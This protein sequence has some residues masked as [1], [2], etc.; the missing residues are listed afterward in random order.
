MVKSLDEMVSKAVSGTPAVLT[1]WEEEIGNVATW[2]AICRKGGV[3]QSTKKI[4]YNLNLDLGENIL[5][6]LEIKLALFLRR[7]VPR[8]QKW[9]SQQIEEAV[10]AFEST[11]RPS[12][13][14]VSSHIA[15]SL[16]NFFQNLQSRLITYNVNTNECFGYAIKATQRATDKATKRI[17]TTMAPGYATAATIRGIQPIFVVFNKILTSAIRQ[18]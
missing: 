5:H 9:L 6:G 1:K 17:K 10:T 18:T 16:E 15:N 2:R 4:A 8:Q 14:T 12:C 13:I 11:L 7:L 3:H